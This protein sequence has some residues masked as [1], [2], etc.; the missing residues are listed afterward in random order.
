M[1]RT[2]TFLLFLLSL[3]VHAQEPVPAAL[4]NDLDFYRSSRL[5][6]KLFVH[7]DKE[8]YLTGEICWFKVYAVDGVTHRPLDLSKVAYLEW[9]D[10]NNKPVLQAKIGLGKGHGDGSLYLPMTL[11]SGNYKLR[12]YTNWM[13]NYG[14]DWYFEKEMTIVNARRSAETPVTP[15]PLQYH[16]SFFPEGGHLVE[17]LENKIA[18]RITDQ[19]ERGVECSG[20]T[21]EDEQDTIARF[22]PYR[23]GIGSFQLTPRPG[24]HYRS[25]FRLADGTAVTALLPA[26][27]KDGFVMNV[28]PDGRD[29]FR[30]EIR[31]AVSNAEVYLIAHTRGTVRLSAVNRLQ[32][33]KT[34]FLVDRDS[35]GDGVSQL[36]IFD[37]ARSPVCERLVFNYPEHP[38]HLTGSTDRTVYSTRQKISLQVSAADETSKPVT[39]DCSLSV[40]RVDSM[41]TVPAGHIA[42]YLWL[43]AD[44]KGRI[45]SPEYYFD[46][47]EDRLAMDNLMLSHGWRRFRWEEVRRHASPYFEF[48]P[49]Y[50]GAIISGRLM[51]TRTNSPVKGLVQAYLS[52]PGT[53]TQFTSA[54]CDSVGGIRFELKD[55]YGSQ[56]IIVQ[57]F[58]QDSL[59]RVDIFNP[60][61]ETY[62]DKPLSPFALS[63][64]DSAALA[65]KSLATQIQ[66]RYGGVRLKSFHLPASDDTTVFY[67]KPDYRYLLDDYT[68]FTTMEEVLREYVKLML[69]QRRKG[70]YHLP[71][72]D[73]S[74]QW[75][76]DKDPLV[77]LDGVPVSDLDQFMALD[78]LKLRCLETVQRT[79]IL[80]GTSYSGIMNWTTFKGD[81][82]GYILDPHATVVDYE[83][84]QL[85]R[86]FYSPSYAA[87]DETGRHLPDFR[88]V[89]YWT[90]SLPATDAQGKGKSALDF[91]S[92]DI[93]GRYV[94]V[95][96]GLTADGSAGSSLTSF[97]VK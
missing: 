14:V 67:Y 34:S 80:G 57:T 95:I 48:P 23:F 22:R 16:V 97:E 52:V 36:T 43:S 50:N 74:N 30:V 3:A 79:F 26:A 68:R 44:L 33:G 59:Q 53:R 70:H 38:L 19:Y 71:L 47:P 7:T 37:A 82:G 15:I 18:F 54:Y 28:S 69:V 84:L 96:E 45:E 32:D 75:F 12:A 49:E 94:V 39:A 61:S 64:R 76:F 2:T 58:S 41:Q 25:V 6:E 21:T 11:R 86:E 51:D 20:V 87:P 81:L 89:L 10:K 17:S 31:S 88:N 90:P 56:E 73:F 62:T 83:G 8:F 42:D 85:Q 13:K 9:L 92:S 60:F 40:F 65:G 4:R 91:Y 29:R 35:L 55:F 1:K 77:L 27:D 24:H 63:V 5:Q 66:S 46:H 72:Y 78:P 93:P